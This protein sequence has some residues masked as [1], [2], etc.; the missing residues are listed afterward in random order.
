MRKHSNK[1]YGE[2]RKGMNMRKG[3]MVAAA[4]A[5]ILLAGCASIQ[6]GRPETLK[7]PQLRTVETPQ[8]TRETLDNGMVVFLMEDRSLPL[9]NFQALIRTGNIHDPAGK[10]G[11][12]EMVLET[13][14]TGGAAGMSGDDIDAAL[15]NIG[16]YISAGAG[17]DSS[18]A[19]GL[20]HRKNF[21]FVFDIFH[22]IMT[23]PS[24]GQDKIELSAIREKGAI[25]R[26]NDDISGIADR[27]FR[28]LLYGKESPY[29][30]IA[31]YETI[32]NIARGDIVEF[33]KKHFRPGNIILGV[34]GDFD[35]AEML[36]A[37]RKKFCG[38]ESGEAKHPEKPPVK[39][40]VKGTVNLIVKKDAT[41]SVIVMGHE[42]IRRDHPDYPAA[43]VL[44]RILGAGWYS[45]FSRTLR[46][47]KGL[48]YEVWASFIPE[49]DYPGLFIAKAQTRQDRT[50]EAIEL[51]KR[52]IAAV[53][54]GVT[55]EELAVAKEGILNSEVF[56]SDTK[57]K[58]ISRLMRYECYGYPFD[59]PEKLI[60][61]VKQVAKEDIAR[62]A[63]KLLFPENLTI[64]VVGNPEKFDAPLPPNTRIIRL[65][66]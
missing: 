21:P 23:L 47:E 34:W 56:W 28:R 16:A 25:S 59:Y 58:I 11:L 15:E 35:T 17:T 13:L 10:T 40:P 45:R 53:Q 38:W 63:E 14:R 22:K 65:N 26:R 48:A 55:D 3:L 66:P 33:Y 2:I 9:I 42:G 1:T 12:A 46:Q 54:L 31:E 60:E 7:F 30:R 52:G 19:G 39:F 24:F 18:S 5:G 43:V 51:M 41:Q 62:V 29:A 37:V 64:L 36:D 27:E 4:G 6:N 8:F 49:F 57:D 44:S 20:A 61:G 32:D 50:F